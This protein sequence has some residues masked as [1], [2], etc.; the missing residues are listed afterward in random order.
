M[1]DDSPRGVRTMIRS[2]AGI[3]VAMAVMNVGNYAFTI[4]A[5][6]LL[7]P[8]E[9]SVVASL[10]GLL[11]IVN[12]VS[13]GLQATGAR[14]V[15]ATPER[16]PEIEA[17][18]MTATY[19]SA[20]ALGLLCLLAAPVL[21]WGLGLEDWLAAATLGL[22]AVPIT[23]MGG[24]AGILQGEERWA[25]LGLVYLS[26]GVGRLGIGV[27]FMAIDP[28]ALSAMLAVAVGAWLPPLVGALA[29]GH[30]GSRADRRA[31][32]AGSVRV[33]QEVASN[34]HALLA[35]FALTNLDIVLARATFD[36]HEAGL[37][38]GGLILAKAVLFL[39]GFVVV[40]AFPSMAS[41][42]RGGRTYLKGL[43]TVGGVGLAAVLG[44]TFLSGLA[45]MFVGGA[46]YVGVE[47]D[48][49]AFAVLGSLMAM[50]QVM[51]YEV[52]ARQHGSS[53]YVLWAGLLAVVVA[54]QMAHDAGELVRAVAVAHASVLLVL[55]AVA[56]RRPARPLE[57]P[58][59]AGSPGP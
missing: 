17:G 58:S 43:A 59:A 11:L 46:E 5:A 14:R 7:G 16:R 44:A 24:Q 22:V 4:L 52:V 53:V 41:Q 39:P 37:Y 2:G 19:R 40:L 28:S 55:L 18:V 38:A 23:L 56:V 54:T 48:L 13:L 9:Y 3:A 12:V 42:G 26:M 36:G 45:Q 34:S 30:V 31:A 8:A 10:M 6:R 47:R 20:L 29:L 49:W 33:L 21:S 27:V 32:T 35:F 25:A 15:A 1:T 51:V 57:L 50:L